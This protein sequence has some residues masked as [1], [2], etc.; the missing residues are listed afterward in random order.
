MSYATN[1][2]Y[3]LFMNPIRDTVNSRYKSLNTVNGYRITDSVRRIPYLEE[4]TTS[5]GIAL[6]LA[7]KLDDM[8]S[9][10]YYRIL[11]KENNHSTLLNILAYTL[12]TDRL[13]NIRTKKPIYFISM[14]RIK[15]LKTKFRKED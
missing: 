1:L 6:E 13:G 3:I 5:E 4:D 12:E 8:R 2:R 9:L 10:D 11:A 7:E 14:C 15:E